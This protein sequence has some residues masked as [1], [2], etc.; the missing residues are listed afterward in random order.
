MRSQFLCN[1]FNR[2][3]NN[4]YIEVCYQA[5]LTVTTGSSVLEKM[6][7]NIVICTGTCSYDLLSEPLEESS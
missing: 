5:L 4:Y 1:K 6:D 3:N 2:N 7:I